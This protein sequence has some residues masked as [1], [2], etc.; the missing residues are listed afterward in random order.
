M[1]SNKGAT[2]ESRKAMRAIAGEFGGKEIEMPLDSSA[3]DL[4]AD[5]SADLEMANTPQFWCTA[6]TLLRKLP[7]KYRIW[8]CATC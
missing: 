2:Y 6:T 4:P 3:A 5:V 7:R 8:P 1:I